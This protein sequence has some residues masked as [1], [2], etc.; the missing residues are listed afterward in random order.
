MIIATGV[1]A[2]EPQLLMKEINALNKKVTLLH[3]RTLYKNDYNSKHTIL[4]TFLDKYVLDRAE[5]I[6]IHFSRIPQ[7]FNQLKIDIAIMQVAYDEKLGYSF[8]TNPDYNF[9]FSN[10]KEIWVEVNKQMPWTYGPK[11]P[12]HKIT[13]RIEVDYP[14]A[15]YSHDISEDEKNTL[16]K[17]G[18][19]INQ[20]ISENCTIQLGISKLQSTL[21]IKPKIS[22]YSEMIGDWA[23]N[24]KAEKIVSGFGMGSKS[25]YKWLDHNP[26]VE[27]RPIGEITNPLSFANI[28]NLVSIN[29]A[30]EIDL[31]GQVA[32]ESLDYKQISGVGGSND[33]TAGA[34]ISKGGISIIAMPSVT[35][36][37]K[38]K[39]VP[40]IQNIVTI[41]RADVDFIITEFGIAEMQFK[42]IKE[43]QKELIKI[44]HPKHRKWLE[45]NC[46]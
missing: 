32:S 30:L 31:F 12:D 19:Y 44:A 7:Y 25:F 2:S 23:M 1:R 41:S 33:F 11:F 35:K 46:L 21:Q 43:R 38:S 16:A 36:D 39:I 13:K 9:Y 34:A 6:P 3:S 22:V 27:L 14:L 28:P 26:K 15:E 4:S 17:I 5:Y 20:F 40:K 8:G 45:K 10:A 37:G 42:T 24:L 29:S 18:T